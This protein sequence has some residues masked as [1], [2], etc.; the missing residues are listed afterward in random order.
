[1]ADVSESD[2]DVEDWLDLDGAGVDVL[3]FWELGVASVGDGAAEVEV[4]VAST[5]VPVEAHDASANVPA[6]SAAPMPKD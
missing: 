4:A 6:I 1:M 3:V 5:A 2:G